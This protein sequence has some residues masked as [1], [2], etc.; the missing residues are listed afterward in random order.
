MRWKEKTPPEDG[1]QRTIRKFAWLPI[2]I[3]EETRWLET[4]N[5]LQRYHFV[6]GYGGDYSV[7]ENVAFN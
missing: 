2:K 4:V 7:W 5:V 6:E 3:K 1:E